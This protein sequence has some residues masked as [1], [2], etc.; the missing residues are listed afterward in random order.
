ML[1]RRKPNAPASAIELRCEALNR[2]VLSAPPD[3]TGPEVARRAAVFLDFLTTGKAPVASSSAV[4]QQ[5]R[6]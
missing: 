4:A 5:P 2:A 3:F 6:S 1:F